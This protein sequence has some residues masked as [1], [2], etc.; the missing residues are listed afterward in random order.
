MGRKSFQLQ[1]LLAVEQL[2]KIVSTWSLI[3]HSGEIPRSW[4]PTVLYTLVNY[5]F[6]VIMTRRNTIL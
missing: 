4:S 6:N 3:N 5:D 1:V 2:I